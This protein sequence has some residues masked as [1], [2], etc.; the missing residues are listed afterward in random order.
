MQLSKLLQR[1]GVNLPSSFCECE[2]EDLI[3]DSRKAEP[4]TL[5]IAIR[6]AHADGH[7]YARAAYKAG[8]RVFLCEEM[9]DLPT[10]A[11]QFLV[12][13]TVTALADMSALFF[14]DPAEHL[15]I[16]GV[17]GTKGKTTTSTLIY[18]VL[19]RCGHKAGLIGTIGVY[20]GD[21]VYPTVNIC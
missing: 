17:T 18:Q 9:V 20:I 14:G 15:K 21:E 5:F 8:C 16:I 6:G 12:K 7:N 2:I 1:A 3:Y 13:D 10:D 11:A 19:N 4:H